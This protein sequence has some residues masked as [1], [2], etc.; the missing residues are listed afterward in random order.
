[1]V[2]L[3]L[4]QTFRAAETPIGF[5]IGVK[6]F[7]TVKPLNTVSMSSVSLVNSSFLLTDHMHYSLYIIKLF[8]ML[9]I[10]MSSYLF[11]QA[12]NFNLPT[13]I[14]FLRF[15]SSTANHIVN[16]RT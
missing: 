7:D 10:R 13:S 4:R 12:M 11:I 2:N 15:K 3:I 9:I 16:R 1:M 5:P 6:F 8:V 14:F